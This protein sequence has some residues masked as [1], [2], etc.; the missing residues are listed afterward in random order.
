MKNIIKYYNTF[1]TAES[2]RSGFRNDYE[3]LVWLRINKLSYL[4][5][6]LSVFESEELFESCSLILQ[7]I[8]EKKREFCGE[9]V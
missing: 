6:I 2:L 9:G 1:K 5:Y 7:A 4:N 8:K 3:F